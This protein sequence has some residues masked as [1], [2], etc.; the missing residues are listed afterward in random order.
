MVRRLGS[1]EFFGSV[2]RS[3][4]A[5]LFDVAALKAIAPYDEVQEHTHQDAHFVLVLSGRY[6]CAA[7]GAPEV[8]PAPFVVFN[9]PGTTHR[10]RF[11]GGT[12]SFLT[13]SVSAT[14][15]DGMRG[16]G[17]A[18]EACSLRRASAFGAA[19]RL[20]RLLAAPGTDRTLLESAAWELVGAACSGD[21]LA[22]P[23][24]AHTAFEAL[25]DHAADPGLTVA[26]LACN[27]GVHPV[28]LAQV[29]RAAWGTS[30]G[31]L[32]RWRR[33]ERA[34]S[35][36][37]RTQDALA[38]IAAASGFADQSHMTHA[39]RAVL[40]VTPGAWRRTNLLANPQDVP[41]PLP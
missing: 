2:E 40:G 22:V 32:L 38:Q 37:R 28:H 41:R 4:A 11:E 6:A 1:G 39:F 30:P 34:A 19:L 14:T 27:V 12:G 31:E 3:R 25:M 26:T 9:P 17:I 10:D 35:L 36:L 23:R 20:A 24:W 16:V 8:A 33:V 15:F 21:D 13:V 29:F 5:G 7:N 18:Q